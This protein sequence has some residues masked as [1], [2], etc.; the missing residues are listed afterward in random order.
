MDFFKELLERRDM[1][2]K[3]EEEEEALAVGNTCIGLKYIFGIYVY[4]VNYI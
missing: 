1:V 3:L 4:L 2:D